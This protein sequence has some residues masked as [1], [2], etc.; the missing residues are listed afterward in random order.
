MPL[1][2]Q[3]LGLPINCFACYAG[4]LNLCISIRK[5][6]PLLLAFSHRE[7]ALASSVNQFLQII[8]HY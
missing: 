7:V 5:A 6:P 2:S 4:V 3:N 8:G 1:S